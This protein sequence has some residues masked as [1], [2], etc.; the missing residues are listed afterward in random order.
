[1]FQLRTPYLGGAVFAPQP[2]PPC[3]A[4]CPSLRARFGGAGWR[5]SA[6][7]GGLGLGKTAPRGGGTTSRAWWRRDW[8]HLGPGYLSRSQGWERERA[9]ACDCAKRVPPSPPGRAHRGV[10]LHARRG[11]GVGRAWE[12]RGRRCALRIAAM[13]A[14]RAPRGAGASARPTG[15]LAGACQAALS[16]LAADFRPRG[17][18]VAAGG[19][20]PPIHVNE[21]VGRASRERPLFHIIFHIVKGGVP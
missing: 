5:R 19:S 16:G 17:S 21:L 12:R 18:P 9:R 15:A 14:I 1:M 4:S 8:R 10:R 20:T 7:P 11:G 6:A 3:T 2:P 13:A